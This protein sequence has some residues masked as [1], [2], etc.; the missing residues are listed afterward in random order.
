[1]RVDSSPP[2]A[3]RGP[4]RAGGMCCAVACSRRTL[5]ESAP[6]LHEEERGTDVM[7]P[8]AVMID[9][10][11]AA[12]SKNEGTSWAADTPMIKPRR[13]IA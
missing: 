10:S 6:L 4:H 9:Y 7:T 5:T 12:S 11:A 3:T 1:M 13:S 2:Y 8:W